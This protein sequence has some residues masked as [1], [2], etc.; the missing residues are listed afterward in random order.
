MPPKTYNDPDHSA[1][2]I[3]SADDFEDDDL[4]DSALFGGRSKR[5]GLKKGLSKGKGKAGD[6][7]EDGR[8]YMIKYE[9]YSGACRAMLGR[10]R[11]HGLGTK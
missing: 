6:V 3:G 8:C 10:R 2:E 4:D 5:I 1:D 7:S 9:A 11:T